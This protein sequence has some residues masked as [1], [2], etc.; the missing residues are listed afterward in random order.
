MLVFSSTPV[1]VE[2]VFAYLL[3]NRQTSRAGVYPTAIYWV[4][5]IIKVYS[6]MQDMQT[7]LFILEKQRLKNFAHL[8]CILSFAYANCFLLVIL[9]KNAMPYINSG[10]KNALNRILTLQKSKS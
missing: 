7:A 8:H 6:N 2:V 5:I 1:W 3:K 9:A 10:N 4:Y